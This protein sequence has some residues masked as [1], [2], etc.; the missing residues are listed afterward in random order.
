M[1]N[2]KYNA[3]EPIYKQKQAHSHREQAYGCKGGE[4]GKGW[5]GRVGVG[6]GELCM[7]TWKGNQQDPTL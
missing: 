4:E 5:T 1:W 2:L 7:D 6:R 3:N